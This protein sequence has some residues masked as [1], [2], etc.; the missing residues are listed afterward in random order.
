[1][2]ILILFCS[3]SFFSSLA[4][5]QTL[6]V[7][8]TYP[9]N[10]DFA[11]ES[12]SIVITFD[13]KVN[14]DPFSEEDSVFS[15]FI[16]PE[17]SVEK[18]GARLSD[19]SLS[20]IFYGTLSTNTDYFAMV[21]YA[22]S[23]DG[24]MLES[25][26]IFQFTTAPT[27]GEFTVEGYLEVE[28]LAKIVGETPILVYLSDNA[29]DIGIGD[30]EECFD[31]ECDSSDNEPKYAAFADPV[32]GVYSITGVREGTYYPTAIGLDFYSE[33]EGF[34]FP[35][36]YFYD[37]DEN[38]MPDEII[39]NSNTTTNNLLSDIWLYR[40]KF[41]PITFS[42]AVDIAQEIILSLD[43]DPIILGGGTQYSYFIQAFFG[44]VPLFKSKSLQSYNELAKQKTESLP[45]ENLSIFDIISN[46]NG[47]QIEWSIYGYDA[48]KDS[49][50]EISATPFGAEFVEYIGLEDAELP[51]GVTFSSLKPLPT[52]YID[53][54]SAATLIDLEGG[55]EF[56]ELFEGLF[57]YWSM[58]LQ[59]LHN[60]W[61]FLPDT[62]TNAP[63]LWKAEYFGLILDP[64]S[65]IPASGYLIVMIDAE[66]GEVVFTDS[67]IDPGARTSHITYNEALALADS[68]FQSLPNSPVIL[69]GSTN[70]T[71]YDII[72]K[73]NNSV[74]AQDFKTKVKSVLEDNPFEIN[75]DGYAYSWEI[76]GYD[77]EKDSLFSL[78]VSEFEVYFE[79]Y[80]GEDDIEETILFSDLIPLPTN[81]I[82]SDSAAYII[83]MH[84]GENFRNELNNS[85][86]TWSW[87]MD[88][89]LL[90]QFWDYPPNPTPS[91]PITWTA[92]YSAWAY[93]DLNDEYY[94]DSLHV[95]LDAVSG[96]VLYSTLV[97]SAE[98]EKNLP[99]KFSL[100]QNYPNPF[101]PSTNIPFELNEASRV[102]INVY[103][104]LGQKVASITDQ[105]YSAGS[106]T[107][108]WDA[109]NLSSGIYIYQMN[110]SGFS[111][112]KKLILLK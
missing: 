1:M 34:Y 97:T 55:L 68:V 30:D 96:E 21:E 29:F 8:S 14:F 90:H 22:E 37:P 84:G 82:D 75:P 104:I 107:I 16:S 15:F 64:F 42:E 54:D 7:V 56:R 20:V 102:Q 32:T 53:S 50:I 31:E 28:T 70:Y 4:Y 39:V 41:E 49:L 81:Y 98:D 57:G 78:Y 94:E 35:E 10:G 13:K 62:T 93:D 69:G 112:T 52:N 47:M 101:N 23:F 9:A 27:V 2:K 86:L 80:V 48:V 45:Y 95:Y 59:I 60:Y 109:S 11:V 103:S 110:A 25:P 99:E 36:V 72:F 17:D 76:Y 105:Q 67:E 66:T 88:L 5:A 18:L 63:V 33:F 26:Y 44:D 92:K 83:E 73:R 87:E 79:G 3:L 51:E 6:N 91:A 108:T 100:L 24:E 46:P 58:D 61:D 12:D 74:G 65:G 77:S 19:D 89:Q 111:Q 71:N 85:D 106:H 38:L 40:L 43:N